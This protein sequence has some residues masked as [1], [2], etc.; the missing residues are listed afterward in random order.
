MIEQYLE[1]VRQQLFLATA[2][3]SGST[4]GQLAAFAENAQFCTE[5]Y[6]RKKIRVVDEVTGEQITLNNPPVPGKQSRAKG[7]HIPLVLPVEY[8]TA[9]W[10]RAIKLLPEHQCAW[11]LWCYSEDMSYAHQEKMAQWGWQEFTAG[12]TGK[13]VARKTMARLRALIWLAAQDV[14]REVRGGETYQHQQLA[15]L[16]GVSKS[17]WSETY[18]QRWLTMRDI[19]L[20]LDREALCALS[21]TRSQQK[22]ANF[23]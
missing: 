4:K 21:R 9:S 14:Q 8:S 22:T 23:Q 15:E 6:R 17:T 1:Y 20:N 13:K 16:A 5:R 18:A 3:L 19:F 12:L 2:D 7:S 10:R 11:L